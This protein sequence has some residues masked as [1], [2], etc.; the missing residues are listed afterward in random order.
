MRCRSA[1]VSFDAAFP[2]YSYAGIVRKLLI[3]YKEAKRKRL[4]VFLARR[5]VPEIKLRFSGYTIVPVPP[6]PG[7]IRSQGWDQVELLARH[8]EKQWALPVG[9]FLVRNKGGNE[10]KTL[11]REGRRINVVGRY[12]LLP[13]LALRHEHSLGNIAAAGSTDNSRDKDGAEVCSLVPKK[14]LL[15]DDIMTTG[16]T[17]SECAAVL[18]ANGSKKVCAIVVAAD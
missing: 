6:R 3:A 1:A 10:Q 7:K 9:R 2:L 12:A 18:K 14:V 13:K 11:D 17:L 16:A 5:L 4:S 8:L 15:L